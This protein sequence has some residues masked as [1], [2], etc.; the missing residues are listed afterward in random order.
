MMYPRKTDG[1]PAPWM[2]AALALLLACRAGTV[3]AQ[4]AV[5]ALPDIA[6]AAATFVR[7]QYGAG[8]DHLHV[9]VAQLDPRLRLAR[10]TQP[11]QGFAPAGLASGARM[12][13]GVRCAQP[14]WSVFVP[15]NIET[16]MDVLVLNKA[17]ARQGKPGP[18]DINVEKR[19]VAGFP[20]DYLTDPAQLAGRHL[21]MAAAPG[22]ALTTK[23]LAQDILV[24][25]GQRVTLVAM[26]GSLEVRAQG[27]AVADATAAGRVRVL[28]LGSRRI[29]EGRVESPDRVRVDL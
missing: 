9:T 8:A 7:A 23:L 5:Q 16:E 20:T 27:E 24:K 13:V 2:G 18:A 12:T 1:F 21:K 17:I 6:A 14:Q 19:R 10:C 15:V 29:V 28:N 22:T 25:R 4:A 11:L 26:V 3:H